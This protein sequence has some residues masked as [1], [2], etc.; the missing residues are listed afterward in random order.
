MASSIV[1]ECWTIRTWC[2]Q[3]TQAKGSGNSEK[4][5]QIYSE[6][7]EINPENSSF[8]ENYIAVLLLEENIDEFV[9]AGGYGI[10]FPAK[11]NKDIEHH[12]NDPVAY[13]EAQLKQ[14]IENL[15]KS[16]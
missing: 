9:N 5:K 14:Q 2:P 12:L 15:W 1:F 10:L 3:G 11:Y 7:I 13:I 4:A 8:L 16:I 6:L